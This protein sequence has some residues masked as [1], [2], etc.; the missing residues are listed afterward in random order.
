MSKKWI[1]TERYVKSKLEE[2]KSTTKFPTFKGALLFIG[3][4]GEDLNQVRWL[5]DAGNRAAIHIWKMLEQYKFELEV[6]MEE[7]MKY[8]YLHPDL[9]NVKVFNWDNL[10]FLLKCSNR[11]YYDNGVMDASKALPRTRNV[12]AEKE[13][14]L[15]ANTTELKLWNK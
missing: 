9:A 7:W 1:F 4:Y 13:N 6:K 10:K 5:A 14:V 11:T 8:Q 12:E 2:Y 15:P 3:L